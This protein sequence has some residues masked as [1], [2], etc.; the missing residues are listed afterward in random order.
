MDQS[1]PTVATET[2]ALR[3]TYAALNRGD[4]DAAVEAFAPQIV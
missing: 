4:I 2:D 1:T 3:E